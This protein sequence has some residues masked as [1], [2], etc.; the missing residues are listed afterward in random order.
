MTREFKFLPSSSRE[1]LARGASPE[2]QSYRAGGDGQLDSGRLFELALVTSRACVRAHASLR[3]FK[4]R[5]QLF[6]P[7]GS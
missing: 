5:F 2:P 6:G 3:G 1:P 7:Q 4:T